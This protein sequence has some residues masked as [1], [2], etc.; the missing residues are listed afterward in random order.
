M[1][2]HMVTLGFDM[3][4]LKDLWGGLPVWESLGYPTTAGYF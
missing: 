3:K 2:M 4:N 1:A